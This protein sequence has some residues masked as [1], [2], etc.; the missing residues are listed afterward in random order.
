MA[1]LNV[2]TKEN[3]AL[4]DSLIKQYINTGDAKA[5]KKVTLD[6][7]TLSFFK[8]EAEGAV[9]DYTLTIPEQDLTSLQNRIKANEDAIAAIN[10]EN[11]GI[12]V[13]SKAYT[14]E[15]VKALADGARNGGLEF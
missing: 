9:A 8:S 1:K 12:L 10:N 14:D 11:T 15:K 5:I 4:Y 2:F 3:L 6:G 13:Q 7:R